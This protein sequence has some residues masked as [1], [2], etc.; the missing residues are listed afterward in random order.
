MDDEF[1]RKIRIE[2]ATLDE[3]R[4]EIFRELKHN[5]K[6]KNKNK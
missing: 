3:I 5:G 6:R 4:P 1:K 2:W